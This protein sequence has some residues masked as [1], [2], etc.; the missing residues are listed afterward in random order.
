MARDYKQ[1]MA[2][3]FQR[4]MDII[5]KQVFLELISVVVNCDTYEDFKKEMYSVAL[6]Y[7]KELETEG[8]LQAGTVDKAFNKDKP[9]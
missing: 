4:Q 5:K 6:G 9:N 1:D 2:A 8:I 7:L 3:A